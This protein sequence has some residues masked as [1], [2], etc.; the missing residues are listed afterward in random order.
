MGAQDKYIN[1]L[2]SRFFALQEKHDDLLFAYEALEMKYEQSVQYV[3][4][5]FSSDVFCFVIKILKVYG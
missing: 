5:R 3:N 1:E 2:Q 4:I